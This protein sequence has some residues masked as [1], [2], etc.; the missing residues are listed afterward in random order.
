MKTTY[1][2]SLS[3]SS[4]NIRYVGKS[5]YPNRRIKSH[6]NEC[7]KKSNA[8]RK[9]Q[10][11]RSLLNKNDKPVLE[12]LDE[13]PLDEWMFWEIYWIAQIKA[14]GFNLTNS[15]DGGYGYNGYVYTEEDK[16][17]KSE[18]FKEYHKN[19]P[20]F[21]ISG[22][23]ALKITN[24]DLLY[25]KYIVENLS[26]T[27]CGKFFN[28]AASNVSDALKRY[29][30]KKE[31][32]EWTKQM[33]GDKKPLLQYSKNGEFIKEWESVNDAIFATGV[34]GSNIAACCRCKVSS[35]GGFIW[36]Y[37]NNFITVVPVEKVSNK[38]APIIQLDLNGNQIGYF[39]S[40]LAASK[41][42]NIPINYIRKF[43]F[44]GKLDG[45]DFTLKEIKK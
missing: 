34:A 36:R 10:W 41:A 43:L 29:G 26:T 21:N 20:K 31:K 11:I 40:K 2:Y 5:S 4:G 12:I 1:I 13:V 32:S 6:I 18:K 44:D 42:L 15:A 22:G 39:K 28:V 9:H 7:N 35:A 25:Q 8:T 3:D 17:K 19:N 24:R 38:P 45:Y 37:K 27:E 23:N 16:R 33:S 14:W 30:I